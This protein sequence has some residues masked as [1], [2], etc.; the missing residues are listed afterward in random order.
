MKV[1]KSN[2]FNQNPTEKLIR[3]TESMAYWPALHYRGNKRGTWRGGQTFFFFFTEWKKTEREASQRLDGWNGRERSETFERKGV[4]SC[5]QMGPYHS[6][7][8]GVWVQDW[9]TLFGQHLNAIVGF[10]WSHIQMDHTLYISIC[11]RSIVLTPIYM[12]CI[13]D[14][15]CMIFQ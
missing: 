4:L 8:N 15:L 12:G 10:T 2:S 1:G 9:S 3:E 7:Q 13:Y 5:D 6:S 11:H 14:Q